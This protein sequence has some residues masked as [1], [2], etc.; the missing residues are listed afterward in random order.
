MKMIEISEEKY[1]LHKYLLEFRNGNSVE[2]PIESDKKFELT[3]DELINTIAHKTIETGATY[4]EKSGY[5][6]AI[7]VS[8]Y[9]NYELSTKI[10]IK[11]DWEKDHQFLSM[12]G[13]VMEGGE[14]YKIKTEIAPTGDKY[15]KKTPISY[16]IS[17]KDVSSTA[18]RN[19]L[20]YFLK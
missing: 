20:Y 6:L 3:K 10:K 14:L 5:Y 4:C 2:I 18:V 8:N 9:F 12:F 16:P 1:Y 19:V 17:S 13:F 11:I 15:Y 7:L